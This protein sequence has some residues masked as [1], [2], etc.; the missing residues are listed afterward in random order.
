MMLGAPLVF[1]WP[2]WLALHGVPACYW[3]ATCK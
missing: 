2:V 3:H 1:Y